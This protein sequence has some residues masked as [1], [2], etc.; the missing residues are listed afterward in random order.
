MYKITKRLFD[1]FFSMIGIIAFFPL[2]LAIATAVKLTSKGPIIYWSNRI[3]RNNIVFQMPKFRTMVI[4][5]PAVA[6][7]LLQNPE[8]CLTQIGSFLRSFSLD[9]LPQFYS[10]LK[11]DMSVVGP[12]PAL[13]NQDDLIKLRTENGIHMLVP[14][15]T[16][17][18]QVNGRDDVSIEEKVEIEK[19]YIQKKGFLFDVR[20]ILITIR[21]VIFRKG[22]SH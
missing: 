13:F 14:G 20:I 2:M 7:H 17:W 6:T 21:N 22:I 15:V 8:R 10:I 11:G 4:N 9:E 12:R 3:G 5:T 19:E 1:V 16:G 18:A